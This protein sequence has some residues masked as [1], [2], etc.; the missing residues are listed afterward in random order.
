MSLYPQEY[1]KTTLIMLG[2]DAQII[3]IE[4]QMLEKNAS[5]GPWTL[6]GESNLKQ[7]DKDFITKTR[8]LLPKLLNSLA[9]ME[10]DMKSGSYQSNNVTHEIEK[11]GINALSSQQPHQY[12]QLGFCPESILK[13]SITQ[14]ALAQFERTDTIKELN[15]LFKQLSYLI[16]GTAI[17]STL[18]SIISIIA[19][20]T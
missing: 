16:V 1:D 9:D 4:L 13:E 20:L 14:D 10:E 11:P 5:A 6:H 15:F 12:A 2:K 8:F 3:L 19:I 18:I 17:V 7:E